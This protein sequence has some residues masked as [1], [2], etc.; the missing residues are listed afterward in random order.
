MP[1]FRRSEI[2]ECIGRVR[3]AA[4]ADERGRALED[5]VCLVFSS[6][7][8]ILPPVRNIVDFADGGEIDIF[9]AN[10]GVDTGLWFLP[11]SLLAECKNWREAV[12]AE[13]LRIFVD[14]LRERA[15][16]AGIL[17]AAH[18]ITGDNGS[19]DGARRHI[20]R[21]LEQDIHVLVLTLD[22]IEQLDNRAETVRLLLDK[23]IRLKSFLSSI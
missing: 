7:P 21:A 18:G 22:E 9:F 15:C 13:E 12:G 17:I 5:L 11:I 8:G 1:R 2:R 16:R 4:R 19:L 14:R 3:A 10:K 6:I 20:A 23:W